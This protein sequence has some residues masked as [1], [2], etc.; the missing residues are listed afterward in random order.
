MIFNQ[1]NKFYKNKEYRK[2]KPAVIQKICCW[3]EEKLLKGSSKIQ[4]F[5]CRSVTLKPGVTQ[6]KNSLH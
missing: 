6:S 1:I 4:P 5:I 3:Y 2:R